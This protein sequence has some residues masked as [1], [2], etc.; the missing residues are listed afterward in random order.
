MR[1]MNIDHVRN[2]S[3]DPDYSTSP[4]NLSEQKLQSCQCRIQTFEQLNK[5]MA[6]DEFVF[7]FEKY[8]RAFQI[9]FYEL[10]EYPICVYHAYNLPFFNTLLCPIPAIQTIRCTINTTWQSNSPRRDWVWITKKSSQKPLVMLNS[11][12]NFHNLIAVHLHAIFIIFPPFQPQKNLVFVETITTIN[13]GWPDAD[14]G[15]L[16]LIEP[17]NPN[18]QFRIIEL[19]SII[20]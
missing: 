20:Q 17:I 7:V 1:K 10:W 9:D 4:Y 18:I 5:D 15:F 16:Q 13:G 19:S 2:A 6:I 14:S 12:R 3:K 11:S 8:A